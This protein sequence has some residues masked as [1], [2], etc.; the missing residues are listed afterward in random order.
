LTAARVETLKTG[1]AFECGREGDYEREFSRACAAVRPPVGG[2]GLNSRRHEAAVVERGRG[3][4]QKPYAGQAARREAAA[5][6]PP[7][8]ASAAQVEET[9]LKLL[10]S[11]PGNGTAAIAKVM[12]AQ[13]STTDERLKR[14]QAKGLIERDDASAGWRA[15]A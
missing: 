12:A 15:P 8:G 1:R 13:R 4:K 7:E 10:Q 9:I 14:L 5:V 11:S 2:T 3:H 6:K